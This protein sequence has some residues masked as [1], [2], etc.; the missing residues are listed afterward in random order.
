MRNSKF[1]M[2]CLNFEFRIS[3]FAFPLWYVFCHSKC[4]EISGF[5]SGRATC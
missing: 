3:H 5:V 4:R 1:E 2:S